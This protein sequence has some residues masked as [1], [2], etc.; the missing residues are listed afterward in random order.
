[1]RQRK[2]YLTRLNVAQR[3]IWGKGV[4]GWGKEQWAL[5]VFSDESKFN[6]FGS[7]GR[8]WCRRRVREEL[9]DR[10][11]KKTV[12]HGGGSVMVW[13]CITSHGVGCL[14]R[15]HRIMNAQMYCNI[16]E[17][18]LLG[19]LTFSSSRTMIGSTL[20][21]LPIIGFTFITFKH[22]PGPLPPLI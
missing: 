3:K 12:K 18:S 5:V 22:F 4:S 10:N 14:H 20:L 11:V 2:P 1:M 9:L 8:Q 7:D 19:T 21:T 15:I 17:T 13:G 16:L 6:L